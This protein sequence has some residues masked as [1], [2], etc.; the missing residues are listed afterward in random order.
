MLVSD[1]ERVW[2]FVHAK[3]GVPLSTAM[4][5]LGLEQDGRLVAGVLYDAWNGV[6]MWMH[7]AIEPGAYLG[8]IFPWYVFHY[9]FEEIGCQRLTGLV[10]E[11]NTEAMRFN[12]KLG[13]KAE[14][15]LEGAAS[16][17][18]DAVLMVMTRER[19]RWLQR[20]PSM[21]RLAE[22]ESVRH[23]QKVE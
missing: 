7:S 19:C 16:D 18:K 10:E 6:N 20:A 22:L 21:A 17:G 15:R 11:S 9:P 8:R 5:V 2:R 14:G 3:T 23:G 12:L 1:T 4:K 13:F